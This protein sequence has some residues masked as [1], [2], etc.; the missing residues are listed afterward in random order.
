VAVDLGVKVSVVAYSCRKLRRLKIGWWWWRLT[1]FYVA[2]GQNIWRLTAVTRGATVD[3]SWIGDHF[4]VGS[5]I[6]KW[7]MGWGW[8]GCTYA[9]MCVPSPHTSE[10]LDR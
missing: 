7:Q 9:P 4:G 1:L 8:E 10:S 3:P 2:A 5:D 6:K